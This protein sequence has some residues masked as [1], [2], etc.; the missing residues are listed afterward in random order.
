MWERKV[1]S[2]I[3]TGTND[4]QCVASLQFIILHPSENI[5]CVIYFLTDHTWLCPP[6][7]QSWKL[8]VKYDGKLMGTRTTGYLLQYNT[9]NIKSSCKILCKNICTILVLYFLAL[10]VFILIKE[11]GD[12]MKLLSCQ[13]YWPYRKQQTQ[14]TW[15]L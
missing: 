11:K 9:I 10:E 2:G 12:S 4:E 13:M 5:F 3:L 14:Y 1:I 6:N 8:E 15:T 7:R